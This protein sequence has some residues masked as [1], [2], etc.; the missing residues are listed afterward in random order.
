[1]NLL[2]FNR[3]LA[4]TPIALTIGALKPSR[5]RFGSTSSLQFL[6]FIVETGVAIAIWSRGVCSDWQTWLMQLPSQKLPSCLLQVSLGEVIPALQAACDISG[7]SQGQKRNDCL[8]DIAKKAGIFLSQPAC[9]EVQLH[10]DI[11]T[12]SSYKKWHPNCTPLC[13]IYTYRGPGT[14]W[15]PLD[16]DRQTL[17][18]QEDEVPWSS[19]M[20]TADAAFFKEYGWPGQVQQCSIVHS[21]PRI[22]RLALVLAAA[23]ESMTRRKQ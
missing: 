5:R 13:M 22:A 11:I 14:K 1:M 20:K 6:Q 18:K 19:T 15:V 8:A 9:D 21:S 17:V 7:M 23:R 16:A 2:K 12:N 4:S 3:T 10:L